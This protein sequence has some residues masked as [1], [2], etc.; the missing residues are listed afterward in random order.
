MADS[1]KLYK[2]KDGAQ[3]GGVLK[4]F[5]EVYDMDVTTV[6][7]IYVLLT[8]FVIG[9]PILLYVI[10]YLILPDKKDVISSLNK[11]PLSDDF[12]IDEDEY[13]Y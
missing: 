1:K 9:S 2:T 10:F 4:G 13:K 11:E 3:L 12:T 5:S 6:R 8:L 7:I